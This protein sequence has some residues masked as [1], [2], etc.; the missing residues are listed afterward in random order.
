MLAPYSTNSAGMGGRGVGEDSL[1][2][3]ICA[4]HCAAFGIGEAV[5][6]IIPASDNRTDRSAGPHHSIDGHGMAWTKGRLHIHHEIRKMNCSQLQPSLHGTTHN[7]EADRLVVGTTLVR[8]LQSW[9]EKKSTVKESKV[10]AE[11][12][13]VVERLDTWLGEICLVLVVHGSDDAGASRVEHATTP[14]MKVRP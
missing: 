5:T 1:D 3:G 14:G 13:K 7:H 12:A 9:G 6:D 4:D 2:V 10:V 8:V 11:K